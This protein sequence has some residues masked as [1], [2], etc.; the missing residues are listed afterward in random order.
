MDNGIRSAMMYIV[1][2]RYIQLQHK[3]LSD[4]KC[5]EQQDFFYM[6]KLYYFYDITLSKSLHV[7]PELNFMGHCLEKHLHSLKSY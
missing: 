1:V 3:W 2:I 6:K 5:L 7:L 4:K